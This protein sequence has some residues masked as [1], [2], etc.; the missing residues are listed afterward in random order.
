MGNS[1]CLSGLGLLNTHDRCGDDDNECGQ[2]S[3]AP[4]LILLLAFGACMGAHRGSA[5]LV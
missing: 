4:A 5:T 1:F 2:I 3:A